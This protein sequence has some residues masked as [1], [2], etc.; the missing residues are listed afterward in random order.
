MTVTDA[1]RPGTTVVEYLDYARREV[2]DAW[3]DPKTARGD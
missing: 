2:P 1:L 3:F